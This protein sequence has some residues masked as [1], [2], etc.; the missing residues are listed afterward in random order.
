MAAPN[1]PRG[2][3][4]TELVNAAPIPTH[5]LPEF[6]PELHWGVLP[7]GRVAF[8]DSSTYTVKV[9]EAGAGVVRI[10]TRPF[11]PEP[12]TGR[13]IRADKDRRLRRLEETAAPGANLEGRR[14]RIENLEFHNELSVIWG[15][16]TTWTATSG[17]SAAAMTPTMTGPSTCLP[18]M[19][20]TW[21]AT[22]RA[23]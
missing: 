6:S 4:R 23:R 22:G 2:L 16:G 7:D 11:Q 9:A 20:A 3:D 8:A 18:P 14:S 21:A 17:C 15:L 5:D 1:R 13:I 12:V 10:L 19:A